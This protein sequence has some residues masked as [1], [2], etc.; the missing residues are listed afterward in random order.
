M[1]SYIY[2]Y[3]I[4]EKHAKEIVL[5]AMGQA[6]SKTVAIAEILKVISL[7]DVFLLFHICSLKFMQITV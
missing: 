4:Q 5:K 7:Q 1:P 2:L 3:F 6:I